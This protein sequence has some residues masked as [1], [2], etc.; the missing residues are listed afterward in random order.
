MNNNI[1]NVKLTGFLKAILKNEYPLYIS[2]DF[3][4]KI[5]KKISKPVRDYN[6]LTH[7]LRIASAVTF[8]V[9][10]LF[11]MD[12]IFTDKIQ[13]SKS[14]INQEILSPTRNVANQMEK[15]E[16]AKDSVQSSDGL[17]CK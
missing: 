10:T 1:K 9:I 13:Y 17:K 7:S 15:C 6:F 16:D 12:N 2:K 11:V 3:S 5:M 4:S 14:N 8:A